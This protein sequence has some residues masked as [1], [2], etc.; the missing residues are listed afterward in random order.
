M[1]W[2]LCFPLW[3]RV[4][5]VGGQAGGL[6]SHV[7]L[8][9]GCLMPRLI[10]GCP[11]V[12]LLRVF[13]LVGGG[14]PAAAIFFRGTLWGTV[15]AALSRFFS[16]KPLRSIPVGPGGFGAS[17]A[18]ASVFVRPRFWRLQHPPGCFFLS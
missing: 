13:L 14:A 3:S 18:W 10:L 6:C 12:G 7:G 16:Q 2:S 17:R 11:P 4:R 9:P 1:A 5:G 8:D 15:A